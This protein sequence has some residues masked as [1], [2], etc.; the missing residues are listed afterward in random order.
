M[1]RKWNLHTLS[2]EQPSPSLRGAPP[3]TAPVF[4]RVLPL[5]HTILSLCHE[6]GLLI[7]FPY[8]SALCFPC[9]FH[10]HVHV[11]MF[12]ASPRPQYVG[13]P[14]S[15]LP[16]PFPCPCRFPSRVHIDQTCMPMRLLLPTSLSLPQ[17]GH[18]SLF[19]LGLCP[20]T[21]SC[22]FMSLPLPCHPS[23]FSSPDNLH[24]SRFPPTAMPFHLC[25]LHCL[26]LLH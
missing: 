13:V 3:P 11:F 1:K 2:D 26:R 12:A 25:S 9:A 14:P 19:L 10:F 21:R 16:L 24:Q 17:L 6:S 20:L 22:S 18:K 23:S 5:P 4:F 15:L 7:S 8:T